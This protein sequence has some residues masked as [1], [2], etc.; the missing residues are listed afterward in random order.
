MYHDP[1]SRL[2]GWDKQFCLIV[3]SALLALLTKAMQRNPP[4]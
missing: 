4:H 1:H 2:D 3:I